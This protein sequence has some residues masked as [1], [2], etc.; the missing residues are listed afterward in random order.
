M[1][2]RAWYAGPVRL[3]LCI[4]AAELDRNR[5]L[6]DYIS[7]IMDTLDGSHGYHFTHLPVVF[8][9]GSQV[10]RYDCRRMATGALRYAIR[11]SFIAD[12]S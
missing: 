2:G 8:E 7:G 10:V 12:T 11:C 4:W 3:D 6:K 1:A 9:D 5:T